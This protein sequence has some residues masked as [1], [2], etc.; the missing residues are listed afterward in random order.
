MEGAGSG[1]KVTASLGYTGGDGPLLVARTGKPTAKTKV[2]LAK[3]E[4]AVIFLGTDT[5]I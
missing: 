5:S 4:Q 1:A 3:A 2:R